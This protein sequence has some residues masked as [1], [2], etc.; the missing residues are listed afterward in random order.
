MN[1]TTTASTTSIGG[2]ANRAQRSRTATIFRKEWLEL[3]REA[4]F[5]WALGLLV[6]LLA[7]A[8][9]LGWQRARQIDAEHHAASR[10]TYQQWLDQGEK[11]PHGAAHFGQ[12]AFKPQSALAFVD[13][14]VDPYVGVTVWMEAHK[15]NDFRFR[16]ARDATA[17][18]RFG[19]LTVAFVLQVLA[20]LLIILLGFSAFTAER[21]RG[22]LKQLLGQGVRPA[23]LLVGKGLAMAAVLAVVLIPLALLGF[24]ATAMWPGEHHGTG[25]A[26]LRAGSLFGAYTIYLLGF[27]GV[28]LAVSALASSS[29]QA[30]IVLLAFWVLNSFVAPRVA[31]DLARTLHPTPSA[32]EFSTRVNDEIRA[33]FSGHDESH[34]GYAALKKRLLEQYNVASLEELPF[35]FRGLALQEGEENSYRVFDQHHGALAGTY[36]RQQRVRATLGA[37]FPLIAMQRVS[38]GLAGNDGEHHR[39][40]ANAAEQYRRQIQ[41]AMND[42][43]TRNSKFGTTNHVAGRALWQQVKP[44]DYDPPASGWAFAQ[45]RWVLLLVFAWSA[46][47]IALAWFGARRL[48]AV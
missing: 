15:Q 33:G 20:P 26:L 31:T 47:A 10:V 36:E 18:Q 42:D 29:R 39:H 4:R 17:L 6:A 14:G 12:Y 3:K 44:F 23:E 2:R 19:D 24:V 25:D 13:P 32:A 46:A 21:E 22:T 7:V 28:T 27:V 45:Q 30:L 34:P 40:F 11:N 8:L 35:N 38:M 16:P 1:T 37:L 43:I 9:L 48:R 41:Q 5:A